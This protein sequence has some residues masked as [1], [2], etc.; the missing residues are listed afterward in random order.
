MQIDGEMIIE[1]FGVDQKAAYDCE[2]FYRATS[3]SN[4]NF[5]L[6]SIKIT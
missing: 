3:I 4:T 2:Y 1:I 6:I 5:N